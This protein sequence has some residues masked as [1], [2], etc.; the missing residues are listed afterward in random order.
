MLNEID[1]KLRNIISK[2]TKLKIP[3]EQIQDT[4]NLFFMGMDSAGSVEVVI[5]I[6]EEFGFE[7]LDTD[8]SMQNIGSIARL[9]SYIQ[10]RLK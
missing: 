10:G 5:A 3:I 7:F 8:L 6:E 1:S 4:D 9:T 2:K